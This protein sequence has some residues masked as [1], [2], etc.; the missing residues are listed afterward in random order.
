MAI[1]PGMISAG[2]SIGGSLFG[3][4]SKKKAAKKASRAQAAAAARQE[5]MTREFDARTQKQTEPYRQFGEGSANKL[6]D[7]LGIDSR[8]SGYDMAQNDYN[9]AQAEYERL[10]KTTTTN[11]NTS[12][13]LGA[14]GESGVYGGLYGGKHGMMGSYNNNTTTTNNN[15]N[16]TLIADAKTRLDTARTK[17]DGTARNNARSA[18]FGSMLNP[19]SQKDLDNDV[20]YNTGLDFGLE[21]GERAINNRALAM[22]NY[23]SGAALKEITRFGNDY[24]NQRAGDAQQR[25]MGDKAFTFNSLMGG[26]QVG[27]NAVNTASGNST[28]ALNSMNTSIGFGG[29]A[30]SAGPIARG[31]ANSEMFGDIGGALGRIDFGSLFGKGG[32]GNVTK[33]FNF[34]GK[35]YDKYYA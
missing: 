7:Y 22:G 18:T 14:M 16:N 32:G 29:N 20:V 30:R 33:G 11:S 9:N 15:N 34:G 2:L 4:K 24:G 27:Q 17:L 19:F 31:N 13:N 8:N 10:L 12:R 23:D 5:A 6:S 25:F 21:Q 35:T 26:T 3:G 28:T 1:S